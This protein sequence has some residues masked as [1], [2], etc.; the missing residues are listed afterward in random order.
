MV[1]VDQLK[2]LFFVKKITVTFSII[3]S[4]KQKISLLKTRFL[5]RPQIDAYRFVHYRPIGPANCYTVHHCPSS[6]G[7]NLQTTLS[8]SHQKHLGLKLAQL[9]DLTRVRIGI[10]LV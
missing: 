3:Y 6:D 8:I 2:S 10:D 9:K 7:F 4:T 5:T 1:C